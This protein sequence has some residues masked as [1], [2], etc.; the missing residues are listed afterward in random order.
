MD[1]SAHPELSRSFAAARVRTH[2]AHMGLWLGHFEHTVHLPLPEAWEPAGR[3]DLGEV[4]PWRLGVLP[5]TKF[6]HFRQDRVVGTVH[7]AHHARWTAHELLHRVV[8]FAWAPGWSLLQHATAARLAETL[9]VALW[10][11]LEE[12]TARRC[13]A[14]AGLTAAWTLS[15]P[16]CEE[17]LAEGPLDAP[18]EELLAA[19]R[20][21]V[22]RE[23]DA[24]RATLREGRP[25]PSPWA[26]IDLCT[27]GLAYV[28]AHGPRLRARATER[29]VPGFHVDGVVWHGSL[30]GLV[31][32]IE[33]VLEDLCGNRPAPMLDG[34]PARWRAGDVAARL[35]QVAEDCDEETADVLSG[36]VDDLEATPDVARA[37]EGYRRLHEEVELPDPEE[38]FAVGYALPGEPGDTSLGRAPTQIRAGLASALPR[39]LEPLGD[40]VEPLVREFC[41]TDTLARVALGHRFAAWLQA[42]LPNA[43]HLAPVAE[44]AHLEATLAHLAPCDP[45]V[46]TLCAEPPRDLSRTRLAPWAARVG[47]SRGALAACGLVRA[48]PRAPLARVELLLVRDLTGVGVLELPE[49]SPPDDVP[50]SHL[51]ASWEAGARLP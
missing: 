20:G 45:A 29:L 41:R 10:Y 39:T 46:R 47:A 48:R 33:E 12:A 26:T 6:R 23:I 14:H 22:H 1:F 9:P 25:V 38:V 50:P 28:G 35:L 18:R 21:F 5:E 7:P 49:S 30:D 43:P 16:A 2:A 34:D 40:G 13:P 51:L 4:E 32:R 31:A 19:A 15:C 42:T 27:D 36:L 11:F 44:L 24:A 3:P 8:G 37:V 17:A